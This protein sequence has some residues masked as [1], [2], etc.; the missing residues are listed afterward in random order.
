MIKIRLDVDY[1]Y[2]SRN[3]SLICTAL[4]IRPK[5]GYLKNSKIIA[6]MVNETQQDVMVYW[7]FTP[8][9]LP[10]QEMMDLMNSK[11]HEIALHVAVDPCKELETLEKLTNKKLRYYTIHGTERLLGRIIWRRKFGQT[12][13][14]IPENFP[15]Q[16]FWDFPTFG[17]DKVCY[18]KPIKE[19]YK[20]TQESVMANKIL[21]IHPDWL[22]RRGRIN[23][24]GAYYDV[25]KEILK[26]DSEIE[27]VL[28]RKKG[29]VKIGKYSEH[30]EYIRDVNPSEKLFDKLRDRDV[31][32]FTFVERSWC[33]PLALKPPD[34]WIKNEDN[35]AL[36]QIN[37]FGEWW[38]NIG[39][40]T[41]NMVRKAEK[42]GVNAE[43]T[44]PSDILA[45]GI[46][47]I[48]NETP[49]RQG[50][51]F[52]HYGQSLESVR[53]MV[54]NTKNSIFINAYVKDELSGFIQLIFGDNLVV[55]TQILSLQ[56][57]WDKAINN[58]MI[59]KAVE[60]CAKGNHTWLMYGRIGK[61]SSHPSLDKF[62]ENNGFVR[63]PLN[64]YYVMLS[65][66]GEI[67]VKLGLHKQFKDKMPEVLKPKI[68]P[69][70]NF[71]SRTKVKLLHRL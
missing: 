43:V 52:S 55:I 42:S 56:K 4:R 48:Y 12:R 5:K 57:H 46:W 53:G 34:K 19:V 7:F 14:P 47:Q 27:D 63:Y 3:R 15:L 65:K 26:V 25:L 18:D 51:T 41:R 50:R 67:A 61:G 68:I 35:I 70:Y 39:K 28:V 49:I 71:I 30:F 32:I 66:K 22:F 37:T 38:E 17:L 10:D 58:V 62:K 69:V 21:H 13:V 40:K 1:A 24:R 23:H 31:D 8:L 60:F 16:D 54:F 59:A 20:M 9:T 29:F 44:K 11:L 2:P 36:L 64:R 45:E 33:S 6:K